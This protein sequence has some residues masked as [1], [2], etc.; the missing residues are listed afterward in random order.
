MPVKAESKTIVVPDDY[1]ALSTAIGNATTGDTIIV[2][3]GTYEEQTLE[4]GKTISLIGEDVTNT[5]LNLHPPYNETMILTHSVFTYSNAITVNAN[6]VRI[7]NLTIVIVAPGGYISATGDRVQ[8]TGNNIITGSETGI[9][10]SGSYCNI[11]DNESGGYISLSGSSNVVAR[12]SAYKIVLTGNSNMVINNTVSKLHL[13]NA[14]KNVFHKN[15][16]GLSKFY[17]DGF[18]SEGR[19][20]S[21]VYL[22]GNSSYNVFYAN[23]VAAYSYD[24]EIVKIHSNCENNMFYHNNFRNNSKY[25]GIGI[26]TGDFINFWD[27]GKEGN[28]WED[29]NGTDYNRDGIGDTPYTIDTNNVDSYPLISPFDI[30]GNT[31]ASPPSEILPVIVVATIELLGIIAA[32]LVVYF[33]QRKTKKQGKTN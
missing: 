1:P 19:E 17:Y 16:I 21:G 20:Y 7:S 5:V 22:E 14:N 27:N 33:T 4:I 25:T 32:V 26:Q 15:K 9:S 3:K 2:K 31:I 12:N 29:Y 8:I 28:Y 30:D 11:T 13:S 6:D 23:D 18:A 10:V 24:V